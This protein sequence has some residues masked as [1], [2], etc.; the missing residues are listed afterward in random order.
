MSIHFIFI[1]L[2]ILLFLILYLFINHEKNFIIKEIYGISPLFSE[3]EITDPPHDRINM[4]TKEITNKGYRPNDIVSVDYFSDGKFLNATLWFYLPFQ[5]SPSP[6]EVDYGMF[7][8]SDFN[9]KTG[10]GGMDY[11]VEIQWNQTSQSWD[12]VIESWS[13]YGDKKVLVKK[14]NY[15]NFYA[16]GEKY[17]SLSLDLEKILNPQKYKVLFY[18]DSRKTENKPLIIDFTRWI[19]IPPLTLTLSTKPNSIELEQGQQKNIEVIVNS[20]QG[21]EPTINLYTINKS[22]DIDFDFPYNKLRVPSHGMISTYMTINA[23]KNSTIGP[24]TLFIFANSSF[25]PEELIKPKVSLMRQYHSSLPTE[26]IITQSSI[27]INVKE[28]PDW[29][30][31]LGQSW[32]K[33]GDFTQFIYGIIAG[34]SPW[35]LERFRRMRKKKNLSSRKKK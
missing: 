31:Q 13:L 29:L 2:L 28:P 8:D 12:Y 27:S 33:V 3:Q 35:I 19:A 30:T 4:T 7:I 34:L 20:T 23:T 9:S 21:Y 22:K 18:T 14:N 11:K 24:Q 17:V 10:F 25:P 5:Q 16:I 1:W 15:T 32:E 6:K 26:N